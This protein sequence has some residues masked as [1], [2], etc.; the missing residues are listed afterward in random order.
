MPQ[1]QVLSLGPVESRD[2]HFRVVEVLLFY[3]VYL[4][5]EVRYEHLHQKGSGI[6]IPEPFL[7]L[8]HTN[9]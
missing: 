9:I 6:N 3:N 2:T 4:A 7:C 8:L 5:F 1:V